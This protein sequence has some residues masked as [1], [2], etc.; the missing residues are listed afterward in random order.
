[1]PD[2]VLDR[3]RE[4]INHW[5]HV[6]T[7]IR[8][9][10]ESLNQISSLSTSINTSTSTSST[11]MIGS[12]TDSGIHNSL[13]SSCSSNSSNSSNIDTIMESVTS[14]Y[15]LPNDIKPT[16]RISVSPLQTSNNRWRT[17]D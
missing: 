8:K 10:S 12:R 11:S 9:L 7:S 15:D 16:K 13:S 17:E 5:H 3:I 14:E 4:E 2:N 1:M 6:A